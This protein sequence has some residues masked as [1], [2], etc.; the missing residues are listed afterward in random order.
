MGS[1]FNSF[2]IRVGLDFP[3][4][5]CKS[6]TS[7]LNI[8]QN[9]IYNSALCSGLTI[10]FTLTFPKLWRCNQFKTLAHFSKCAF[11]LCFFCLNYIKY[12]SQD[13]SSF[14]GF[15]Q[16]TSL[17]KLKK[18]SKYFLS[19]LYFNVKK[20]ECTDTYVG[21]HVSLSCL[22]KYICIYMYAWNFAAYC[23]KFE[24]Q[25][26]K[27]I[28]KWKFLKVLSPWRNHTSYVYMCFLAKYLLIVFWD[29]SCIHPILSFISVFSTENENQVIVQVA[30]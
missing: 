20:Y 13:A 1:V 9:I 14:R 10:K 26:K 2:F 15:T 23:H 19:T 11:S 29:L 22:H 30:I 12:S 4:L 18:K 7:Q 24:K 3:P 16:K 27:P 25:K 8:P 28:D 5:F 21:A 17:I 6:N